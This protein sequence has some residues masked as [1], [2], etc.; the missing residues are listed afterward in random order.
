M[1][2]A[3]DVLAGLLQRLLDDGTRH[4]RA[5]EGI[6]PVLADGVGLAQVDEDAVLDSVG[7]GVGVDRLTERIFSCHGFVP[8]GPRGLDH[9]T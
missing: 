7:A 5:G 1:T 2:D 6:F 3:G 8:F 9:G 4:R